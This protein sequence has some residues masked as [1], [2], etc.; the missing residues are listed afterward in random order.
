MP[1]DQLRAGIA[2]GRVISGRDALKDKLIDGLGQIEDAYEKARELGDA[3]TR[4]WCV[5]SRNSGL[6]GC[7]GCSAPQRIERKVQIELPGEDHASPGSRP[8]LPAAEFLRSLRRLKNWRSQVNQF[9]PAFPAWLSAL[10]AHGSSS[11]LAP[12]SCWVVP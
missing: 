3:P 10:L 7:C 6:A 12:I 5:T 2:D 8:A 11:A 9:P 4:R 1:E